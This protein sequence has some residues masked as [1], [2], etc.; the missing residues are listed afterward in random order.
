M[1]HGS[2]GIGLAIML[3]IFSGAMLGMLV[4]G[5]L[6]DQHVSSETKTAISISMAVVG[7]M[8]ALV[9]GLLISSANSSFST[10]AVMLCHL[11]QLVFHRH[12]ALAYRSNV[13]ACE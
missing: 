13:K 1:I 5:L 2:L 12:I 4:G 6:P 11:S 9:L 7:T 8:S 3:I 10:R